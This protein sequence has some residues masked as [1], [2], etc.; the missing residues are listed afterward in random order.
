MKSGL[1]KE[2]KTSAVHTYSVWSGDVEKSHGD[3]ADGDQFCH[4]G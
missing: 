4:P 3:G 2:Q 1:S